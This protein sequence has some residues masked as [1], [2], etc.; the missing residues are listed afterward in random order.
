MLC[1]GISN[2]MTASRIP[3][4]NL[5]YYDIAPANVRRKGYFIV[6]FIFEGHYWNYIQCNT[7]WTLHNILY[8][9]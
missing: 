7:S 4:E 9:C 8:Y 2:N 1:K 6:T 5:K 3:V